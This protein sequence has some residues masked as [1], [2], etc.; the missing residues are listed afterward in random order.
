MVVVWCSGFVLGS[1]SV[2][3]DVD[4]S[5]GEGGRQALRYDIGRDTNIWSY[6]DKKAITRKL[7][8]SR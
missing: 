6:G 3:E 4:G 5:I 7:T 1:R 2:G 8:A